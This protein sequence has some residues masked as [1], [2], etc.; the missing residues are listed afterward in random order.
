MGAAGRDQD[1]YLF[2]VLPARSLSPPVSPAHTQYK[3]RGKP[4]GGD[5]MGNFT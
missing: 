3:K 1:T 4:F 5:Q 2:K